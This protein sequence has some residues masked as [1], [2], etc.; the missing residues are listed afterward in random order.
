MAAITVK[1]T[2]GSRIYNKERLVLKAKVTI[3]YLLAN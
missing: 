1:S 2:C 3:I